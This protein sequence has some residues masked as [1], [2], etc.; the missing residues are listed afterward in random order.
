MINETYAKDTD[1]SPILFYTGNEGD[2]ELFAQNT[3]FMWE[4]AVEL[5]ASLS[6]FFFAIIFQ[7]NKIII[8]S[9]FTRINS[10]C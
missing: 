7:M 9:S 2:I 3:G 5:K 8:Y 1:Y 10:F 6:K 4:L